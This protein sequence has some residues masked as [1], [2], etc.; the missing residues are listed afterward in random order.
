MENEEKDR[1]KAI[2]MGRV[3]LFDTIERHKIDQNIAKL[4]D[5]FTIW[6][7]LFVGFFKTREEVEIGYHNRTHIKNNRRHKVYPSIPPHYIFPPRRGF[8]ATIGKGSFC[9][10]FVPK[11]RFTAP[12]T[13]MPCTNRPIDGFIASS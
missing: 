3:K 5:I 8:D 9:G 2:G 13:S 10:V 1:I 6:N 12:D 7:K 4:F 11:L